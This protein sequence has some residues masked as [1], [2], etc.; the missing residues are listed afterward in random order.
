[1]KVKNN[2]KRLLCGILALLLA[3]SLAGCA[4]LIDIAVDVND[5]YGDEYETEESIFSDAEDNDSSEEQQES[6]D[7]ATEPPADDSSE[8]EAESSEESSEAESSAESSEE[9]GE[10]ESESEPQIDEDGSYTTK[11]DVALYIY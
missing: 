6:V 4:E 5:F 3:F 1:M 11:E 9:S 7:N 10:E 8:S 2:I